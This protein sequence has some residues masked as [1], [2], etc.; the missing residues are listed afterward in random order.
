MNVVIMLNPIITLHVQNRVQE[1]DRDR[2]RDREH[3]GTSTS[4]E[5]S[6]VCPICLTND[7]RHLDIHVTTCCKQTF[8]TVCHDTW[9]AHHKNCP[10]CRYEHTIDIVPQP[11]E[12][13]NESVAEREYEPR[14][15]TTYLYDTGCRQFCVLC[16]FGT[17]VFIYT[18]FTLGKL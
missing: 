3:E 10:L 16:M 1:R 11:I 9:M 5:E 6:P 13:E 7:K 18:W 12:P 15:F 2:D 17:L 4:D 8:H 14:S